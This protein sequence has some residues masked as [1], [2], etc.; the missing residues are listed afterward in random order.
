MHYEGLGIFSEPRPAERQRPGP[1]VERLKDM[2]SRHAGR[3]G[4]QVKT[5]LKAG[6]IQLNHNQTLV[7]DPAKRR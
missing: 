1:R 2:E 5:K 3:H 4:M 6:G 7:R